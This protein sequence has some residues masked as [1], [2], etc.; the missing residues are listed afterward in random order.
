MTC[1]VRGS[2][3]ERCVDDFHTEFVEVECI[4][5]GDVLRGNNTTST[6]IDVLHQSTGE[7]W[8]IYTYMGLDADSTQWIML[9]THQWRRISDVGTFSIRTCR[10]L[11]GINIHGGNSVQVNGVTCCAFNS[12]DVYV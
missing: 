1:I 3:L 11:Y 6:V 10:E 12:N 9:S 4:R 2:L 7:L 5:P 8:P